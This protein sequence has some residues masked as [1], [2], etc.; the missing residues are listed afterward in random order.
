M[1]GI[2]HHNQHLSIPSL[3]KKKSIITQIVTAY[4]VTHN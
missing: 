1:F 2:I 4:A 3:T